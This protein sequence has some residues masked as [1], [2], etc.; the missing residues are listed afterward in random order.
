MAEEEP[1]EPPTAEEPQEPP[2][3]EAPPA[4]PPPAEAPPAEAP[5]A[6]ETSAPIVAEE[7]QPP[8][9]AQETEAPVAAATA[10][11]KA[12]EA[13]AAPSSPRPQSAPVRPE[14]AA[15]QRMVSVT[16]DGPEFDL[17]GLMSFDPLQQLVGSLVKQQS[18][19][20]AMIQAL[21]TKLAA[22]NSANDALKSELQEAL[23]AKADGASVEALAQEQAA[24]AKQVTAVVTGEDPHQEQMSAKLAA[25]QAHVRELQ[26]ELKELRQSVGGKAEQQDLAALDTRMDSY[27]TQKDIEAT[28]ELLDAKIAQRA[29]DQVRV[30]V[31]VRVGVGVRVRVRV[32]VRVRVRVRVRVS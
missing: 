9:A 10:D 17:S 3:A 26:T 27:A 21:E 4:E 20:L 25:A 14:E 15:K 6:E 22:S 18:A 31:G 24:T 11:L 7:P 32:G 16:S 23:D 8:V 28:R 13:A 12:A 5:P 29:E 1:Q 30:R 19:Q 2:P